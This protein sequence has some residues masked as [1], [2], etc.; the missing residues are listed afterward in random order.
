MKVEKGNRCMIVVTSVIL[1]ALL[2]VEHYLMNVE[3]YLRKLNAKNMAI[4]SICTTF[5]HPPNMR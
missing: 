2:N 3:C 5:Y 4:Q 1:I